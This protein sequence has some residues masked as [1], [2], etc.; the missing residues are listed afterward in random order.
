LYCLTILIGCSHPQRVLGTAKLDKFEGRAGDVFYQWTV[1]R[2][3]V[4]FISLGD[5]ILWNN[6]DSDPYTR[7]YLRLHPNGAGDQ[8][9]CQLSMETNDTH[10][11]GGGGSA[12]PLTV[13]LRRGADLLT[14]MAPRGYISPLGDGAVLARGKGTFPSLSIHLTPDRYR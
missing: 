8:V 13:Q 10:G 3:P 11:S 12:A 2:A 7:I 4:Q 1:A 9:T 6:K 5:V 14:L